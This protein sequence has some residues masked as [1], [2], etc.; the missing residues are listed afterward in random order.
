M[1]FDIPPLYASAPRYLAWTQ[2]LKWTI[3]SPPNNQLEVL[4]VPAHW[5]GNSVFHGQVT[6]FY[7]F[8]SSSWQSI[9]LLKTKEL[10][11]IL[12]SHI[13]ACILLL[14]CKQTWSL[15]IR[16]EAA[17]YTQFPG[18]QYSTVFT[19][20]GL[21]LWFLVFLMKVKQKWRTAKLWCH[22][23]NL[24]LMNRSSPLLFMLVSI[25]GRSVWKRL[26]RVLCT[27]CVRLILHS[28][29]ETTS[30]SHNWL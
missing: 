9:C 24:I 11:S 10:S 16:N 25:S 13:E 19:L 29:F 23:E 14:I 17:G 12:R 8:P 7:C 1:V 3:N 6:C 28:L 5:S 4:E 30:L 21:S 26:S 2:V 22:S 18:P 15:F 27:D 20:S